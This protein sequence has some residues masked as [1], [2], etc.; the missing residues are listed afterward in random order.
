MNILFDSLLG[1]IRFDTVLHGCRW[2]IFVDKGRVFIKHVAD[3][4]ALFFQKVVYLDLLEK[5]VD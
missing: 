3:L 1:Q 4:Q 5:Y 2:V